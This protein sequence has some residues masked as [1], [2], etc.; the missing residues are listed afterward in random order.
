M[1]RKSV[2]LR[3]GL[4]A[5]ALAAAAFL[6]I[7]VS[8]ADHQSKSSDAQAAL[9]VSTFKAKYSPEYQVRQSYIGRVEA[10]REAA[11]GFEFGGLVSKVLVDE[12]ARVSK[13]QTLARLDTALLR[14]NRAEQAAAR[15]LA[16]ENAAFSNSTVKRFRDAQTLGAVSAQALDE[17]EKDART[18]SA[19]LRR[20]EAAIH[21]ID[22]KIR[23]ANLR[24]PFGAI[25][26]ARHL[27]E[28]RVIQ[29]GASVLS[30]VERGKLDARIGVAG[31]LTNRLKVGAATS[32]LINGRTYPGVIQSILPVRDQT[33]RS[34]DVIVRLQNINDQKVR[35]GDLARLEI[36]ASIDEGG[37]WLPLSALTQSTR[38]LWAVFIAEP[39][40]AGLY[41]VRRRELEILH[42][43]TGRAFV[44]GTLEVG[45]RVVS[46]GVQ[47]LTPGL[48]V[49]VHQV[50][51]NQVS[52]DQVSD[53]QLS[54]DQSADGAS[55]PIA[56]GQEKAR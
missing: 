10:R 56:A 20:A 32:V 51:A 49:S 19:A 4:A 21:T 1:F 8:G 18:N 27:D 2:S 35:H 48:L 44:R 15:D 54:A 38:G 24:A 37:Y 50:S 5:A 7:L 52:A 45:D 9:T 11:L 41:K 33:S 42:Q 43:E 30:L 53:D 29:A 34:V 16:A 13:G 22:V 6:Y 39:A 12:G 55:I 40:A 26:S 31:E 14:A 25:V 36:E 46:S 28:G 23:K 17:V 47:R 3:I